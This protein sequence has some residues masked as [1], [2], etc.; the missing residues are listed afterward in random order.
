MSEKTL[1][2]MIEAIR[3]EGVAY[4]AIARGANCDISTLFRIRQGDIQDPK[5]SVGKAIEGMYQRFAVHTS[6]PAAGAR[7]RAA[8]I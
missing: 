6:A 3:S 7:S 2:E 1:Q 5:Y 8:V 4:T